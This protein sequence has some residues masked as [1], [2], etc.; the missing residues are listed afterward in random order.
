MGADTS[1]GGGAEGSSSSRGGAED[2]TETLKSLLT[3]FTSKDF[4]DALK[5]MKPS[6]ISIK[7]TTGLL[8]AAA[9]LLGLQIFDFKAFVTGL[10]EKANLEVKKTKMGF[11]KIVKKREPDPPFVP[12]SQL[13]NNPAARAT[14]T[15]QI[16]ADAARSSIS[17][18]E[19]AT[20]RL[21]TAIGSLH[22]KV[23]GL[24]AE[25]A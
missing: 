7:G 1:S 23:D 22:T 18:I 12:L 10:L 11:S 24:L 19:A 15:E 6:A 21:D 2:L 17:K 16:N 13:N 20:R 14:L 25:F 9:G 5:E 3:Q 4:T 8:I